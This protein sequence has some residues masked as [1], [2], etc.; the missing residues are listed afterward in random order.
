[1]FSALTS[2]QATEQARQ[3]QIGQTS[4]RFSRS[5]EQIGSD[6][7]AV[8][9]GGVYSFDSLM[10]DSEVDQQAIVEIL[11]AFVRLR[12]GEILPQGQRE[13]THPAPVDLKSALKVLDAFGVSGARDNSPSMLLAQVDLSGIDLHRIAM[14]RADLLAANLFGAVLSSANLSGANL[15]GAKLGSTDLQHAD[16]SGAELFA[17]DLTNADLSGANLSDTDLG[18]ADLSGANLTDANMS[19]ASLT[20]TNLTDVTCSS[21]TKWPADFLPPPQCK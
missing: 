4:E 3:A 19:G 1:M 21:W 15:G 13:D 17:S 14:H 16:L 2:R 5:V 11:S 18:L 10:R 12:S 7:I 9:I 6:S 8:R 20:S